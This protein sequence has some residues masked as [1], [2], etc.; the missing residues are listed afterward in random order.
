MVGCSK[1]DEPK[2]PEVP[3]IPDVFDGDIPVVFHVMC[4]NNAA[5]GTSQNPAGDVFLRRVGELN[6]FYKAD[7]SLFGVDVGSEDVD[8]TFALAS[9]NPDGTLMTEPGINRVYYSGSSGM[10]AEAFLLNKNLTE[11]EKV[12]LWDPNEYINIWL[13]GF[14]EPRVTGISFLPYTTSDHL[15][16]MLAQWEG[17]LFIQP[18][19]MHGIALNN[20][21]FSPTSSVGNEI[22]DEGMITLCHEMGHYLGLLHA[23]IEPNEDGSS[24]G[25]GTDITNNASDDGC[26]DTPKYDRATYDTWY[27]EYHRTLPWEDFLLRQPCD[28]ASFISTNVMDYYVGFRTNITADQRIRIEHVLDYS[29]WIPRSKADTKALLENFTGEIT[30][31]RPDP[32]LMH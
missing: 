17:A 1:D 14:T 21:Y 2:V 10:S 4:D 11:S 6:K 32:I 28:G 3:K 8:V 23:Y 30:D 25:C 26:S 16:S 13:F 24:P 15:L 19:Y 12:I 27:D 5:I 20:M 9:N 7:T 22:N 31:E 29:P 18:Y